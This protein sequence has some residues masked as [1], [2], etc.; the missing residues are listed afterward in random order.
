MPQ[1]TKSPSISFDMLTWIVAPRELT[2]TDKLNAKLADLSEK[3]AAL[4]TNEELEQAA[5]VGWMIACLSQ[6]NLGS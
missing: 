4:L 2:E 3:E 6:N 1:E 5:E